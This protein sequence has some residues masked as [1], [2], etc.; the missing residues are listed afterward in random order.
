ME[1]SIN[2]IELAAELFTGNNTLFLTKD[3]D[4][5]NLFMA[6]A[7]DCN[8][9]SLREAVTLHI[10]KYDSNS[11]K[12]G[13]DGTDIKTGKLK[14][15]KP[16]SIKL[17]EKLDNSGTFNDMTLTLLDKKTNYDVICSAFS[18]DRLIYI[19]EF[20]FSVIY[21]KVKKTIDNAKLGKR[22]SYSFGYKSYDCDELVVH[23]FDTKT[24]M[25]RNCLSKP[26]FN[27]LIRRTEKEFIE[28]GLT[29]LFK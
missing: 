9:S 5:R 16:V 26:H 10:L 2:N 11:A 20:P 29:K 13:N 12:H 22:V 17:G 8:S 1:I 28:N 15:V 4:Y 6:Y 7:T 3:E 24:A 25:E 19:V 21:E 14:E 18:E 23:Y 27:C